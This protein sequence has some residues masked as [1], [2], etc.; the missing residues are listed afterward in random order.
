[1][2]DKTIFLFDGPFFVCLL[3]ASIK[4]C[5]I[6]SIFESKLLLSACSRKKNTYVIIFVQL[7]FKL[8]NLLS[9]GK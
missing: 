1:M 7:A 4:R 9:K 8:C 6:W 5:C 3:L 2:I